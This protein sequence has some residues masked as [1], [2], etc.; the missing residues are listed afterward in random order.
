MLRWFSLK[1]KKKKAKNFE[2][3][4]KE[5]QHKSQVEWTQKG[6]GKSKFE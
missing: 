5:P 6:K 2:N 1:K 4:H 3:W